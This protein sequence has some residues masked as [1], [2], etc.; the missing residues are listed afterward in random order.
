[1]KKTI[2]F[3]LFAIVALLQTQE[4]AAQRFNQNLKLSSTASKQLL[5]KN[6][7]LACI[8][9]TH[10]NNFKP[11]FDHLNGTTRDIPMVLASL[12]VTI[13]KPGSIEILTAEDNDWGSL[14]NVIFTTSEILS[15]NTLKRSC[16]FKSAN[17]GQAIPSE[18]SFGGSLGALTV[19]YGTTA[20]QSFTLTALGN[21]V[22][23]G[24]KT[25]GTTTTT[26]ILVLKKAGFDTE[27][28]I[29]TLD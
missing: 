3:C 24:S 15:C 20:A 22:F 18:F 17:T 2:F 19:K 16:N 28:G 23:Q 29:F 14:T 9:T 25:A 11:Y 12:T 4:L 5:L 27:A 21:G 7:K 13:V 6:I 8:K 1:M 26:A 10:S